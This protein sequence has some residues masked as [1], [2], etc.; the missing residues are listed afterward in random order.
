[1]LCVPLLVRIPLTAK[2]FHHHWGIGNIASPRI[3]CLQGPKTNRKDGRS[4]GETANRLI[5]YRRHRPEPSPLDRR[6]VLRHD[7]RRRCVHKRASLP[8]AG[9]CHRP[10]ILTIREFQRR[11]DNGQWKTT[12]RPESGQWP[13]FPEG[14]L[15]KGAKPQRRKKEKAKESNRTESEVTKIVVDAATNRPKRIQHRAVGRIGNPSGNRG[16]IGGERLRGRWM[17]GTFS[18]R[19]FSCHLTP[20]HDD[21]NVFSLRLGGFAPLRRDPKAQQTSRQQVSVSSDQP[22]AMV[23][24]CSAARSWP[25]TE[26]GSSRF[27]SSGSTGP[28]TGSVSMASTWT[29]H[30]SRGAA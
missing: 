24:R 23:T 5:H 11:Q 25:T 18:C 12:P 16:R 19:R 20:Q 26:G 9:L 28:C 8:F 1:M 30:R 2:C 15:R 29:E 14:N 17:T 13:D 22:K 3:S 6:P 4:D 27:S 21:I 10:S 7:A